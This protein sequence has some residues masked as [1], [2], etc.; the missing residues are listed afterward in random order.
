MEEV[1]C[2]PS[3]INIDDY[4][5]DDK[6]N[7]ISGQLPIGD[8][9]ERNP[10]DDT[11]PILNSLYKDTV[12]LGFKQKWSPTLHSIREQRFNEMKDPINV[13]DI[14]ISQPSRKTL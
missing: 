3:D 13:N 8:N 5:L 2:S 14:G 9:M 6:D 4:G 11:D 1:Y 12:V 7:I 10:A